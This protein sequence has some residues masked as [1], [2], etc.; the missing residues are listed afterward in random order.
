MP[1][2]LSLSTALAFFGLFLAVLELY[3]PNL[4]RD[5][6]ELLARLQER[7]VAS[8]SWLK[9]VPAAMHSW[10]MGSPVG[11]FYSKYWIA[12]LVVGLLPW[13][14]STILDQP[15]DVTDAM[16]GF[17]L[18]PIILVIIYRYFLNYLWYST[19]VLRIPFFLL[20]R[21]LRFLNFIGK[22]KA[23]SGIGLVM[24]FWGLLEPL[25]SE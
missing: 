2:T 23:L 21:I 9:N 6:E 7:L 16:L 14:I 19:F 11:R 4:S 10:V 20:D 3:I 5:L 22:G 15:E 18:L 12:M 17:G 1:F 24:A 13:I 25:I 8:G